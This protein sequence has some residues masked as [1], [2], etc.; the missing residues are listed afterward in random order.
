MRADLHIHSWVSDGTLSPAEILDIAAAEGLDAIA[1]TDHDLLEGARELAAL[2]QHPEVLRVS[3]VELDALEWGANFHILAY[4]ADLYD[5]AFTA[6]VQADRALLEE[7]NDRLIEKMA[8]DVPGV[9][10]A[11]YRAFSYPRGGGG[12]KALHY[13]MAKGLT[14]SLGEGFGWYARYGH[15]NACVPFPSIAQVARAVHGAGGMAVLAHPGKVIPTG[16]LAFFRRRVEE[17]LDMGLDGIECHYP[18]H[19]PAVT[20]ICLDLCRER[21]LLVT[22]GSDCHGAFEKTRIGQMDAELGSEVKDG[23]I[24]PKAL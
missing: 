6:F 11:D 8:T 16:G 20:G 23:K 18:S 17:A 14:E 10:M 3:G 15:T 4:G 1:I 9:S 22:C 19:G 13:F 5:E 2:P 21:G 7:V 24:L 12:W